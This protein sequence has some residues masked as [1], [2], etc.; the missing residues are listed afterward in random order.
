MT[1]ETP[2]QAAT[3]LTAHLGFD[4][5]RQARMKRILLGHLESLAEVG[6]IKEQPEIREK[7]I[8]PKK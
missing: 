5:K 3:R 7:S 6:E 2:E 4:T 1:E 8:V